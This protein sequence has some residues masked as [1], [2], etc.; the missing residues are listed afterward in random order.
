MRGRWHFLLG[1]AVAAG[2]LLVLLRGLDAAALR[3]AAGAVPPSLWLLATGAVLTSHLLRALR[4]QAEWHPRVGARLGS[5]LRLALLHNAAVVL[6]P[7]RAGELGYPWWLQRHWGVPLAESTASLLWLRLQDLLVLVA[8]AL[9]VWLAL[10][11]AGAIVASS[12][13]LGTTL[14]PSLLR[15]TRA[16]LS[17]AG[18]HW[19]RIATRLL[20]AGAA[21][22]GGLSSWVYAASNWSLRLLVVGGLLTA[23]APLQAGEA[24]RAALGGELAALLPLQA[25]A[26]LGTYEAGIWAGAHLQP[27][28][29]RQSLA[30]LAGAALLIHLWWL[31][32]SLGAALVAALLPRLLAWRSIES[33]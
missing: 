24:I 27:P 23:L 5:C 2:L 25:P 17:A 4:L 9:L 16:S 20:D 28:L 13:V 33:A 11:V 7:M 14:L 19:Q 6:L 18:G 29:L 26:G 22:R 1:L 31:L 30:Q 10:P 8:L 3:Q 32:V 15:Q 21:R 12:V